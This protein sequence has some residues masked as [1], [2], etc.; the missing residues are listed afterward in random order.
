MTSGWSRSIQIADPY[1]GMVWHST[2]GTDKFAGI[3][4]DSTTAMRFYANA[5]TADIT[6]SAG[7][8]HT[9]TI[10]NN[11]NVGIGT[12]EPT[13]SVHLKDVVDSNG[14]DVFYVAQ[15]TTSNRIAGYQV[16]DE[17]GTV[18][19]AM[20]YDNGV[21]AASITNPNN[22]SLAV[23]LGGSAAANALDDYEEGTWTPTFLEQSAGTGTYTKVG[24]LVTVNGYVLC[25]A[26]G[27]NTNPLTLSGLPFG[28]IIADT[29]RIHL[30]FDSMNASATGNNT[31]TPFNGMML[32]MH[33]QYVRSSST[34]SNPYFRAN[35][36]KIGTIIYI[37]GSFCTTQ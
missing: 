2:A 19:L 35:L 36:L 10:L 12:A 17:S 27:G 34:S 7:A 30:G 16:L 15:N 8:Y 4:Y 11:G 32:M 25:D 9:L 31:P 18:S 6:A 28:N 24:R 37:E 5:P 3:T 1:P 13:G 33:D 20:Q 23:Y 22:G 26:N 14:S 29:Y 21:N